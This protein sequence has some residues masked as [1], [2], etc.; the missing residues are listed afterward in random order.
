MN[1]C[2]T[3]QTLIIDG[4][5]AFCLSTSITFKKSSG[6]GGCEREGRMGGG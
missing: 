5:N 6:G 4:R 1:L 2:K 3:K